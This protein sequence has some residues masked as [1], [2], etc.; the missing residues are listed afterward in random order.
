MQPVPLTPQEV[1]NLVNRQVRQFE[2]A[3]LGHEGAVL[4]AA[5]TLKIEPH[6]ISALAPPLPEG[7]E[8]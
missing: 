7:K 1:I 2:E 3:G 4:M 6:K 5:L 8:Q